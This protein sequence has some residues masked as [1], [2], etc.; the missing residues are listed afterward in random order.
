MPQNTDLNVS[1]YFDDFNEDKNFHRILFRPATAVQAR[2][3]TQ[4]QTILQNQIER[5]GSWAFKNG[6]IVSGCAIQ[7]IPLLP[8]VRL[9]D[10]QSNGA[11]YFASDLVNTQIVC[12]SSNLQARVILANTGLSSN[13]PNTSVAY[14]Q[15]LNTGTGGEQVFSNT[16]QLTFYKIPS[17]GNVTA[18]TVATINVYPNS[19]SNTFSTGNAHGI[20]VSDGIVFISG[21]FVK[22]QNPTFGVVNAYGTYAANTVVGFQAY[23]TI[24]SENQDSSLN[25]NAL[26]YENE[27]APGA[28][29]LKILPTLIALEPS[30]AANT[31]GF[32]PIITY[33]FGSIMSKT[34]AGQNVYSI[35][36]DVVAKRT[37]EE[38][39]NYVVNPFV[40]D[41]VTSLIGNSVVASLDANNVLGRINPGV[42]YAQGKRVEIEKTSYINMRRGIDTAVN[43]QQ[44]ISFNYGNYLILNEVA[45][46]FDFTKA[47]T[48]QLYDTPQKAVTNRTFASTSPTG[49]NIGSALL[50]CFSYNSG[51]PGSNTATYILHIFNITMSANYSGSNIKSI[52]YNGTNKGIGD[53]ISNGLVG[54]DNK[55]QLYSFGVSGLKNLRDASNNVNTEYVYRTKTSGSLLTNGAVIIT[56]TSSAPGG[57]DIL[58]YGPGILSDA[59]S[60]SFTITSTANVDSSALTG[61]LNVNTTTTNVTGTSTTFTTNLA[62]GD[63]IKV[64]SDVRTVN[65]IT[66]ATFMTV[67]S[68]F[69]VTNA[70]AVYYKTYRTGKLLPISIV[71]STGPSSFI[72]ITNSTSFTIASGQTPSSTLS[73]DVTFDVLRT[74]TTPANKIIN[75]DRFVKINTT[76]NPKGP[77]CIGFSDIHQVK[78]IYGSSDGSYTT[79]GSDITSNFVYD[80]G[81]RDT[82]YDYGYL[83]AKP[84]YDVTSKPYLLIQLDYFTAN[85][86]SGLG[87]FTVESYP[88]DDANTANTNAIQTKDIPLYVD[89]AGRK[90]SLRDYVDFRPPATSTANNTGAVD[91]SNSTQVT[92]AIS[93]ATVNPS[94]T[95]TLSIPTN[96]L[97]V[98]SYGKNFQADY[99]HY[100][101]R[102]DL[103]LMTP[104]NV[105]KVKEGVSAQ[106][107]QTPLYP[108][109]A[110]AL[111]VLNIPPYPSLSS[112]QVDEFLNINKLSKTLIRDTSTAISSN[113]VT[114]RRYTM[115][116]IGVLDKRITN[117]EYY[118]QLSLL[119]KKAKD[120]TVTDQNGLDRFKN[121]IFVDPFTDFSLGDISNQEYSIAIDTAFGVARPR[122]IREI[123]N[124]KF[125]SGSST[126]IQQ[127]GRVLTLPY[128]EVAFL[129]QPYATKYR[130]SAHVAY[131]WNGSLILVPSYDNH[132]DVNNTGSINITV[133]N[134]KPWKDFA[135][136]PMAY[137]WGDWRT[138]TNVVSTSV[139]TGTRQN[140]NLDIGYVGQFIAPGNDFDAVWRTAGEAAISRAAAIAGVNSDVIRGHLTLTQIGYGNQSRIF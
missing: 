111:A 94:N 115:R 17:T 37:Y 38:S 65:S 139:V 76:T 74:V 98:P 70:A 36:G 61:T 77:W 22:V 136:S 137:T 135:N 31:K 41:T 80:T 86:G 69:S 112:D 62:I 25:D 85:T 89:E 114:N 43:K 49:N 45:G 117:L 57:T 126:N 125:N 48:V 87:Y 67:D 4:L 10:F 64:G 2:E 103:I 55:D 108:D 18:D 97:N 6:D 58:P 44:Q 27:N 50:K 14:I 33:N 131:A 95:L 124:I 16:N 46:S 123:I 23:E 105:I 20:S 116:D 71:P 9:S 130:S 134:S 29:R 81:Q 19:T 104:E 109:N 30:V 52:Y 93:Y 66:N 120:L 75:K 133:D 32:N 127:T 21:S 78:K 91:T 132:G 73:V 101:A 40:V 119:E 68:A 99:T 63:Q 138:T 100:L 83:Y 122:I 128:T 59:D 107:P 110:M 121:G 56:L 42:G 113:I 88:V 129:E 72:S 8:Y 1:P 13:Y 7:D 90:S 54:A 60:T 84:G 51:S 79:S 5:F 47:E 106:N 53:V 35:L 15:Y 34:V 24:I 96:G 12:A 82:H 3:L 118:T 11:S 39:G 28:H 92:T 26:G 102:K 140:I